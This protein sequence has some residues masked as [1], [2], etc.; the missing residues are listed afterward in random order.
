MK[1]ITIA[2][3]AIL[4]VVVLTI[5]G[6]VPP[7]EISQPREAEYRNKIGMAYLNE[8][9][10]QLAYVEFQKAIQIDPNN[11]DIVYNLGI[12][13][14]QLEDYENARKSFLKAVQL[15]PKFADSYNNLGVTYMQLRQWK[16]AIDAF[17]KA[18]ANPLYRTPEKAFYSMGMC[19]YRLGEYD[20]SVDAYKDSIRR[21][22][23]F[24]LP[25]YGMALAYNK[26]EKFGDAAEVMDKAIQVDPAY[27]GNRDRKTA[28]IKERLYTAKGEEEQDLRDYLEIMNY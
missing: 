14:L 17:Q 8:G 2:V 4:I 10:V 21:D 25:Y 12:V 19:Y 7:S 6:C 3:Y 18:L 13:Y 28:D 23:A 27:Q 11:K 26:Q 5:S 24:V 22:R 1:T 15:D 9:K 16:E 20:K